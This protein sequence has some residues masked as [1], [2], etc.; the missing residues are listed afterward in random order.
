MSES[1]FRTLHHVCI[2]ERDMRAAVD[3]CT[4]QGMGTWNEFLSLNSFKGGP[5][6]AASPTLTPSHV[7]PA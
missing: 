3:F 2:V 4:S 1:I 6:L 7:A 5:S